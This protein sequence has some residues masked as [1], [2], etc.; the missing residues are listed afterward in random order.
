MITPSF[1]DFKSYYLQ[2]RVPNPVNFTLTQKQ[3]AEGKW[4]TDTLSEQNFRHFANMLN[5]SVYG[6]RF[7]RYGKKLSMFVIREQDETHRHHLHCIIERPEHLL[8]LDFVLLV[9]TCWFKTRYGHHQTAL[10][11]KS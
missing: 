6:N 7:I 10:L 9:Q 5:T 4:I 2:H 8:A 3:V 1:S 11:H